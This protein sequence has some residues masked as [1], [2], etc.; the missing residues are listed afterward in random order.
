MAVENL[1]FQFLQQLSVEVDSGV[2]SGKDCMHKV[3]ILATFHCKLL[4]HSVQHQSFFIDY[5]KLFFCT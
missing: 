3:P 2:R 5:C 1:R 4:V